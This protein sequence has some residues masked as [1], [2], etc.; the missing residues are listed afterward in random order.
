[1]NLH[2]I[3]FIFAVVGVS[4]ALY[5]AYMRSKARV[6][7][8][9]LGNNCGVIWRSPYSKI[10]GVPNEILGI[11][12]Y[13]TIATLEWMIF[14][15]ST[16]PLLAVGEWVVLA[17][18]FLMSCYFLYLEWRVLRAWC[19]WCTLSAMIVWAMLFIRFVL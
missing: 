4:E 12:F 7:V 6:P 17:F 8:C 13:I 19:F 5:L 15:R 11:I 14:S 2:L 3:I 18:G 16:L 9:V 10:I 1:M